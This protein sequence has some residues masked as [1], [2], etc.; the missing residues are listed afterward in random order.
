MARQRESETT[1]NQRNSESANSAMHHTAHINTSISAR[2]AE[3]VKPALLKEAAQATLDQQKVKGQVELTIAITG[4]AQ[5]RALNLAFRKIDKATDVLSFGLES[6]ESLPASAQPNY[7]GDVIISYP[8]ARAQ[9]KAGGHS[10]ESEL[11][12]LVVHGVLHL[13]GHDHYDAKEKAKMW[14]AQAAV[15]KRIGAE[16]TGPADD[17]KMTG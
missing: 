10:I 15:L 17:D 14:K 5:L 2:Y 4:D 7:L 13:L 1:K 9:A 11:Q 6:P 16:I 8:M 12:L 3:K